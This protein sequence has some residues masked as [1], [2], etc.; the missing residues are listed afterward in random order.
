MDRPECFYEPLDSEGRYRATSATAGPW[1]PN[2]QHGG[3]PAALLATVMDA[4]DPVVGVRLARVTVELLSPIPVGEVK[5]ES[6][7]VRP[8][9]RVRLL[10][11][12]M[13]AGGRLV[14]LARGWQVAAQANLFPQQPVS[15]SAALPPPRPV[16]FFTPGADAWGY[17]AALEW[18]FASGGFDELG[19]AEVWGRVRIPLIA[20]RR[21]T[22]L[23]RLLIFVDSA[24]GVS[25][26]LPFDEWIFV[27]TALTVTLHRHPRGEWILMRAET[28]L[29]EDGIGSCFA[30]IEDMDGP[31]G[32]ASQPLVITR[33]NAQ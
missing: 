8:G 13:E 33:R 24:N 5:V 28:T 11:A 3:P 31:V 25:G 14:A 7:V 26:V 6:Q 32:T 17:A 29:S 2:V 23:Q 16:E 27:P 9:R 22:G 19:P 18:R 4:C 10:E 12:T 30:Y 15:P 1:D 20:E 21:L